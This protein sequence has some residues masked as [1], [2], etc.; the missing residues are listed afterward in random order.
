MTENNEKK[1]AIFRLENILIKNMSLEMPENVVTPTFNATPTI[2]LELRNISRQ[3]SRDNYYEVVLETTTK[4]LSGENV[5]LLVEISQGGIFY[6]ENV[7][8]KQRERLLNVHAPEMLYP[9]ISQLLSDLMM[10]AGAPRI[11][12]PPLI[13]VLCIRRN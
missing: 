13:F 9:Y 6:I 3:L 12:L 7:E 8:A 1:E 10:R 5:Q 2:K 4:V 11:F